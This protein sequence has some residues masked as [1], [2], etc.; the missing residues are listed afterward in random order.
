[1]N[2]VKKHVSPMHQPVTYKT[3]APQSQPL[4]CPTW[5]TLPPLPPVTETVEPIN[6]PTKD[7]IISELQRKGAELAA[8]ATQRRADALKEWGEKLPLLMALEEQ[9]QALHEIRHI[10]LDS[11]SAEATEIARTEWCKNQNSAYQL[12]GTGALARISIVDFPEATD[13]NEEAYDLEKEY[14]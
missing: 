10:I 13:T 5:N 2:H 3:V 12:T 11:L 9:I 6:Q 4:P 1:M 7:K 8:T 14:V